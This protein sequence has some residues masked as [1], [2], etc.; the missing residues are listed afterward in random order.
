[1]CWRLYEVMLSHHGEMSG[2]LNIN[3]DRLNPEAYNS[4][5]CVATNYDLNLLSFVPIVS[6]F[7]HS[8]KVA[9][10]HRESTL[11]MPRHYLH[12]DPPSIIPVSDPRR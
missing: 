11:E 4:I 12:Q 10:M 8:L 2:G 7:T 3:T 9:E 5:N 6:R 1:M